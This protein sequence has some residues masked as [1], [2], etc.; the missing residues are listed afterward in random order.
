ML[1]HRKNDREAFQKKSVEGCA[2]G[3]EG[4]ENR[5]HS[6]GSNSLNIEKWKN[7]FTWK[8]MPRT[9]PIQRAIQILAS[10]HA[11]RARARNV[12]RTFFS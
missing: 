4:V 9:S 5:F 7:I 1:V 11:V 3:Y 8:F 10:A 6:G 2:R 12:F